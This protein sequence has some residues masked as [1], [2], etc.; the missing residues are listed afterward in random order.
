MESKSCNS[1]HQMMVTLLQLRVTNISYVGGAMW[2]PCPLLSTYSGFNEIPSATSPLILSVHS[3]ART[4]CLF[5]FVTQ[6]N[7]INILQPHLTHYSHYPHPSWRNS[8]PL[9]HIIDPC[10]L[11]TSPSPRD[12][13]TSRM[14]SSA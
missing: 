5:I 3:L 13:S 14:P 4:H 10:L 11:Y 9:I 6:S 1:C 2:H 8:L 7:C 12:L